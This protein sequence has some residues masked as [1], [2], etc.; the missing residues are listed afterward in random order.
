MEPAFLFAG[1]SGGAGRGG[2]SRGANQAGRTAGR[3]VGQSSLQAARA[4]R[5]AGRSAAG[6]VGIDENSLAQFG[7]VALAAHVE[8]D[9]L[10]PIVNAGVNPRTLDFRYHVH[11]RIRQ[12]AISQGRIR[13][14]TTTT[15]WRRPINFSPASSPARSSLI[16]GAGPAVPRRWR[17]NA[18]GPSWPSPPHRSVG[19]GDQG[20]HRP[21]RRFQRGGFPDAPPPKQSLF[22]FVNDEPVAARSYPADPAPDRPREGPDLSVARAPDP[23]PDAQCR[24]RQ[25][26]NRPSARRGPAGEFLR[27]G[28][29]EFRSTPGASSPSITGAKKTFKAFLSSPHRRLN[30]HATQGA[31]IRARTGVDNKVLLIGQ[32]ATGPEGSRAD[33]ASIRSPLVYVI[34]TSSTMS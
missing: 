3:P 15:C 31:P 26:R 25:G 14:T 6:L 8:A 24:S 27:Q 18:P 7:R 2:P 30:N 11:R 21:D 32:T 22:G 16:A 19:A 4:V 33:S 17:S 23:V 13:A 20:R 10:K 1:S 9:F 34:S 12:W 5:S 28:V 29:D